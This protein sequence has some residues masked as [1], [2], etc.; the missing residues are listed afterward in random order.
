MFFA[1]QD[2]HKI[3]ESVNIWSSMR[4][5]CGIVP[6]NFHCTPY[7]SSQLVL[8]KK[9]WY[10]N[11]YADKAIKVLGWPKHEIDNLGRKSNCAILVHFDF[12]S[13]IFR[14]YKQTYFTGTCM[15]AHIDVH[16]V[17]LTTLNFQIRKGKLI[18]F[19][20]MIA[21]SDNPTHYYYNLYPLHVYCIIPRTVRALTNLYLEIKMIEILLW[22]SGL[23]FR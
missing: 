19:H 8:T 17:Y 22:A 14:V 6:R 2:F 4:R 1:L 16:F 23:Y 5:A 21:L 18:I 7:H 15:Y 10:Q 11:V 3:H 20:S 9:S 12:F 13:H